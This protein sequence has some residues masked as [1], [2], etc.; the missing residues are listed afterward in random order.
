MGMAA[1]LPLLA[2]LAEIFCRSG[3]GDACTGVQT[4]DA[5]L[6]HCRAVTFCQYLHR[7]RL[8]SS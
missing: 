6:P 8:A 3:L 4:Q 7:A 2:A 5:P 1:V